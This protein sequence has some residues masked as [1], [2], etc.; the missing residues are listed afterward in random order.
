MTFVEFLLQNNITPPISPERW[1][2]LRKEYRKQYQ[3]VYRKE[4]RHRIKRVE[5]LLSPDEYKLVSKVAKHYEERVSAFLK[6]AALAYTH[7]EIYLPLDT[8][9][10][11]IKLLLTR[12]GNLIAEIIYASHIEKHISEA[13]FTALVQEVRQMESTLNTFFVAPKAIFKPFIQES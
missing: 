3:K 10:E 2:E 13:Q 1:Q 4:Y 8:D 11:E 12:S 9:T 7:T 6:K 5:L